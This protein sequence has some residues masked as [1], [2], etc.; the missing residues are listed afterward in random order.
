MSE[1]WITDIFQPLGQKTW[2]LQAKYDKISHSICL[3]LAFISLVP[4]GQASG[5]S[6]QNILNFL[7][8]LQQQLIFIYESAF[9]FAIIQCRSFILCGWM[10][11][12]QKR[13]GTVS[14][15]EYSDHFSRGRPFKNRKVRENS[16]AFLI[17]YAVLLWLYIYD[18]LVSFLI[19]V[20]ISLWLRLLPIV[21]QHSIQIA[22]IVVWHILSKIC[23]LPARMIPIEE[24][25]LLQAVFHASVLCKEIKT[26]IGV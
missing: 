24:R 2:Q 15:C 25:N 9:C 13:F 6:E 12:T 26:P 3:P 1:K 10:N 11:G 23:G 7:M 17:F 4:R 5:Y 8:L 22:Q 14:R 18:Q 21:A 19:D 20:G 16:V